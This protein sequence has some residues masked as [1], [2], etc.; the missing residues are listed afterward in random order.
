MYVTTSGQCHLGKGLEHTRRRQRSCISW[1]FSPCQR[2]TAQSPHTMT[3][4]Q[5]KILAQ[6]STR[7]KANHSS[8]RSATPQYRGPITPS[9]DVQAAAV[10]SRAESGF[11]D[12]VAPSRTLTHTHTCTVTSTTALRS[13]ITAYIC[14]Q[15]L[16]HGEHRSLVT[17]AWCISA[18]VYPTTLDW[19]R[20]P[21]G[22]HLCQRRRTAARV[23]T[24]GMARSQPCREGEKTQRWGDPSRVLWS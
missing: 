24:L 16:L 9:A 22:V 11:R 13:L 10:A 18:S 14:A 7:V 3:N 5:S 23:L 15:Q 4:G 19:T 20:L 8:F 12:L 6:S 17:Q 2:L 21:S 1:Q